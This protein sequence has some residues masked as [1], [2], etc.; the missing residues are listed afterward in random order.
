[1]GSTALTGGF[2]SWRHSLNLCSQF[3][4]GKFLN[5]RYVPFFSCYLN[6]RPRWIPQEKEIGL[7]TILTP[8]LRDLKTLGFADFRPW[9]MQSSSNGSGLTIATSKSQK[10]LSTLLALFW[11]RFLKEYRRHLR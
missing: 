1:M 3:A 8:S 7:F 4:M 2:W 10:L 11:S 9:L 6:L 5:S